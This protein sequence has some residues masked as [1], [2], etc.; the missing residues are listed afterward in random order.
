MAR[1]ALPLGFPH[2]LAFKQNRGKGTVLLEGFRHAVEHYKDS[3]IITMDSDCQHHAVDI[4]HIAQGIHEGNDLVMGTRLFKIMPF[5]SRFA[6]IIISMLLRRQ[7]PHAPNDSQTGFRGLTTQFAAEL[8]EQL[9]AGHYEVEFH[10]LLYALHMNKHIRSVPISTI[11]INKNASSH[12]SAIKDSV[13]ILKVFYI[14]LY[15]KYLNQKKI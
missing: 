12:F 14:H 5:K 3:I 8:L 15:V 9:T 2:V 6:N 7:F 11:Y 13:K 4:P 1:I 10:M